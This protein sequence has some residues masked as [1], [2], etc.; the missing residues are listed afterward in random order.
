MRSPRSHGKRCGAA[1]APAAEAVGA[2]CRRRGGAVEA[3][4]G[5]RGG[6]RAAEAGVRRPAPALGGRGGDS[7]PGSRRPS[8]K[9]VRRYWSRL[10]PRARGL[11]PVQ[12]GPRFPAFSRSPPLLR[13]RSPGGGTCPSPL[14]FAGRSPAIRNPKSSSSPEARGQLF[15]PPPR[16]WQP[17][18][19]TRYSKYVPSCKFRKYV[20]VKSSFG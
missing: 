9:P 1:H 5:A 6:K 17:R 13:D 19:D 15:P 14:C 20:S 3:T 18:S 2:F 16:K 11:G 12:P 10:S 8:T 4:A 7:L